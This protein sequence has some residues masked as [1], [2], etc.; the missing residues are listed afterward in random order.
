MGRGCLE[1][2]GK[3][4]RTGVAASLALGKV[5]KAAASSLRKSGMELEVPDCNRNLATSFAEETLRRTSQ[6][7]LKSPTIKKYRSLSVQL[8]IH[9]KYK[10]KLLTPD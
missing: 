7:F 4:K 9:Y 8:K 2:V 10:L 6:S 1:V 3:S 5:P